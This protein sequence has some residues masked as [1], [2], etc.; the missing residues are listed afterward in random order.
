MFE[1]TLFSFTY[2]FNAYILL[3]LGIMGLIQGVFMKAATA[4]YVA[5]L[6]GLCKQ[7]RHSLAV[8]EYMAVIV[9]IIA[10]AVMFPLELIA[11]CVIFI[12]VMDRVH[13]DAVK[14]IEEGKARVGFVG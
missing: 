5:H 6:L 14:G 12:P 7:N 8:I 11:S 2:N 3:A 1:I 13:E 10:L 9:A 4:T